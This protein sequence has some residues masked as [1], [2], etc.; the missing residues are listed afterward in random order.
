MSIREKGYALLCCASLCAQDSKAE[1]PLSVVVDLGA[2][3]MMTGTERTEGRMMSADV[4]TKGRRDRRQ[5]SASLNAAG[6]KRVSTHNVGHLC[7][8]SPV[9]VS[10]ISGDFRSW[11]AK[12]NPAQPLFFTTCIS[13]RMSFRGRGRGRG[14]G[15]ARFG[16]PRLPS[17][18]LDEV[19][20]TY[21]ESKG[22]SSLTLGS[23]RSNGP[24]RRKA[25]RKAARNP[26]PPAE[27]K[28]KR[29]SADEAEPPRKRAREALV[30]QAVAEPLKKK[31]KEPDRNARAEPKTKEKAKTEKTEKKELVLPELA[32]GHVEDREIEWLEY[33]LKKEKAKD[34][35]SD[36]LDG[37]ISLLERLTK[38]LLDFADALGPGGRGL[39][40]GEVSDGSDSE[41]GSN[42]GDFLSDEDEDAERSDDN[43]SGVEEGEEDGSEAED[44]ETSVTSDE[45]QV[46]DEEE[47]EEWA[48]IAS[49]DSDGE[50]AGAAT[51]DAVP[52]AEETAPAAGRYLPPHMRAAQLAEKAAGD[53]VKAAERV[54]LERKAQGLLNKWVQ[55]CHR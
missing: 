28:G 6:A 48:G 17:T 41:L 39:R 42:L 15:G 19:D 32:G 24:A 44:A 3:E 21:G 31:G 49:D 27:Q 16:G 14:R 40:K 43:E 13:Q 54:K 53:S 37:E 10:Q 55:G 12:S 9:E 35:D 7:V 51:G 30:E 46:V 8:V 29:R 23:S 50:E 34:E 20:A 25:E 4:N 36:G 22:S 2:D 1:R 47:G 52:T 5:T 11:V 38:D 33:M 26:E 18:L 45:Q